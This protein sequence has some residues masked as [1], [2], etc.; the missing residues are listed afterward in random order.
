MKIKIYFSPTQVPLVVETSLSKSDYDGILL[1]ASPD[2]KIPGELFGI[3]SRQ[4][5]FDAAVEK[6][7][8]VIPLP[9]LP[10]G[11]VVYSPTGPLDQD[12]DDVRSFK[13]AAGKGTKR[14]IQAGIKRPLVVLL[15]Y[16]KFEKTQLVTLLGVLE[17]LYAVSRNYG[18]VTCTCAN[19]C[20]LD[21]LPSVF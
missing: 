2:Q 8:T 9:D 21:V 18:E 19:R 15:D 6:E 17:A 12:Y 20:S 3:I 10:A 5:K 7:V 4:R 1:V 14:L 13:D 11:R 16:P